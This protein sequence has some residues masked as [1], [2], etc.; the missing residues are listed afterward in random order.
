[1]SALFDLSGKVALITGSTRGIGKAIA[2][3]MS[4]HGAKVVISSRKAEA[5]A[6]VAAEL[7]AKGREVMAQAANVAKPADLRALVDAVLA[8]WGRID[9]LVCNAAVNPYYGGSPDL[10]E[11]A[12]DLVMGANVKSIHQ[13]CMMVVSQMVARRDGVLIAISS[14]GGFIGSDKIGLYNISKAAEMQMMRNYAVEF[15]PQGIR[16]NSISPGL[17]KTDF[18]KALWSNPAMLEQRTAM[19]PLHRIGEPDEVAGVAV[20]L[21]SRAGAFITGQSIIV[22]GGRSISGA[23]PDNPE[24]GR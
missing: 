7:A 21:A 5:C 12:F 18:S 23:I 11:S 14:L 6:A 2:D 3:R 13:L 1:V 8:K 17:I 9:V 16:A 22:D 15:G 19:S 24:T 4:E 20:F 10:P